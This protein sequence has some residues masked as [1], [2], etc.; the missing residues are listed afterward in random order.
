LGHILGYFFQIK[1]SGHPDNRSKLV[2]G[3]NEA[4]AGKKF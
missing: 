2:S 4:I 1:S 3:E